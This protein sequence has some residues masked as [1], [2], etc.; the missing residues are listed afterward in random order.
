MGRLIAIVGRPNVGKSTL[1]NRLTKTR[2]AIVH[3]E[4]GTTRDRQ[5]GKTEWGGVEMSVVDTGGWVVNSEDIFEEEI[6]KQVYLAIEEADVILFM[7]D[8]KTGITDLDDHVAQ[9]LR[10]SKKPVIVVS[11]K[12]DR[13]D[14]VFAE[15]E[16]YALGLGKPFSISAA[17]GSGTGELLDEV[18]RL[19]PQKS[20]E[21]LEQELPR[22]AIV[23]RPNAGKSSLINS[24]MDEQRNIVTDIAGTTRDSIYSRFNKFGFD[25]YLVDTAGIRKKNKVNEDVEFYSVMRSIRAIEYSDVCILLIDATR[26][27]E[28]QDV[29]IFSIIQKNNKGLVVLVNKWDVAET[30]THRSMEHFEKTIRERFAPFTDFPIIFGS[31]LTRQRILKVLESAIEVYQNRK[32]EIPTSKLNNVLQ[33]AIE[34][35]PPPATKGKYIKIKYIT[36][37]K[38]AKVPTFVFFCNLPQWIREP[39]KRYLENKIRENWKLT[40]TPINLFFREK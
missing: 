23:G 10:R 7:V 5:Y 31:A 25:F 26:G 24:L 22:F 19:M 18:V 36:M 20:E 9:I 32:I 35:F 12:A 11:N 16:F 14:I 28:W 37:L 6:N 34:A 3:D 40:G 2:A 30:K 8:I 15:A 38:G 1:F 39:Y 27:I 4:S 33:P 13:N 21:E 29:N 17:N